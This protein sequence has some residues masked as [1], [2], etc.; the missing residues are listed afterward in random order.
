M[1]QIGLNYWDTGNGLLGIMKR[2]KARA[3]AKAAMK[4]GKKE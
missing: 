2:N 1:G 3:E 4:A